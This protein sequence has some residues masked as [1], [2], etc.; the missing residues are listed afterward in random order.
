MPEVYGFCPETETVQ[1]GT[2][3]L[4]ENVP[5]DEKGTLYTAIAHAWKDATA[6][7][8]VYWLWQLL[9]LWTPLLE[10]GVA[11]S[12]LAANNIRVEGWRVRLCQLFNDADVLA[13]SDATT[14]TA[15]PSWLIWRIAG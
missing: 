14:P 8:Q 4:L 2:L 12:L 9:E 5:L 7:R 6:V 11:S 3:L 10:Q 13:A 1:P 15:A